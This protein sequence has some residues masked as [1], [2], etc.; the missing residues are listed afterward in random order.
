MKFPSPKL[1][2]KD[3]K[4]VK[5]VY[6]SSWETLLRARGVTYHMGSTV[7]PIPKQ[8]NVPCGPCLNP[9]Q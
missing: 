8:V 9:S 4:K 2:T 3:F 7:L 5:G 6:S 1:S